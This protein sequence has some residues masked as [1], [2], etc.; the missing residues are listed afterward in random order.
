MSLSRPFI[1]RPVATSLL[2]IALVLIGIVAVRYLPVSS[3]PNVD[4]PTIQVHTSYP[5]ASPDVM[6]T[7]VT[8]PL[9]VQLGE[10]P[11]LQQMTSYSSDG[12]S[13]ITLQF[14]LSMSLDV[15]EQDVQQAIN[16]ANSYLPSGLPA[17]PTYA[18]VN[19]ADQPILTL[20]VTSKSM[21]LT[22]LQDYANNRLGTKISEVPGVGLVTTAGGNVPAVRVEADP[23]RLAA[24]NLN[25]DDLRTLLANV[26]ISQPKGNFDGPELDYT[27]NDNDQISDPND[28]LATIIAYQNGSPVYLHDVAR[29]TTAAQDVAQGATYN[30][31]PA[32]LLNVQRQPGANVIAT[33]DQIM[34]RLP[35]LESTLPAGVNVTAVSN[36]TGVIRA[37]VRDAAIELVMAVGLVVAV[38]FVFLRNVP[39]TIIPSISVP[40]S[41]IGTLAAMYELH[42]SIDNLSLMALIIATGFVVD[43]SIVM[44]ENVVRYLEEGESPL[45]AALKGAGQIGFTILSLTVSLIA[46]LIP[47]LFMGGVIGRLFSEFAVTLA[48]TVVLSAV[49]S[50]TVVPMLCARI[51]RA[52]AERQ[53]TRFERI[54]EGVFDKTL[55]AYERGLRWVLDHQRLT[56]AVGGGTVVLTVA[57]YIVIA[58][59]LFPIQDVGVIQ[60]ISV[61]DN[62]VSYKAMVERQSALADA[63]LRDRDVTSLTSYVGIDGTN[64]TLN[65]ARFLINLKPVDERSDSAEAIARRLQQEVANV[66]GIKLYLQPEQDLTLDTTVSPNQ[67][68]LAVRGPNQAALAKYV[69]ELV[70]RMKR[71]RSIADVTSDLGN[72]GLG[73]D[74][75]VNRQLAARYG[76]TPA[77]IDNALYNALGQR[78]V[79]TIFQQSDQHRVILVAKPETLPDV[80]SLGSLYLPTQTGTSGQVP[81]NGIATIKVVKSPLAISHLAQFPAVTVSFNLADGASLS[82]AAKQIEAAQKAVGLPSSITATF[83]GAAQAFEDSLSSEVYLIVAAIVAVYIVLGVL[84][85]SF[86]HPVTILS[87][88]PS[89]GVGALLALMIAGRDLDIIGIIGIVLLIGIVKKNAIMIVDFALEAEREHGKPPHEAI[90]EASLLRFRPILMTTMAAMLGA[91]PMLIGNGTGSELR[92]PLG[93]AIIGGLTVSQV[94]TVFTTPVIYLFF[95]RLARR[96]GRGP[97]AAAGGERSS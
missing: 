96:F 27:I 8:A 81:L 69:P 16:A 67:Y 65:H 44:I 59:G 54:S 68:R 87:T 34:K 1:L 63:I 72:D 9:E 22:Q 97:S 40:V 71:I 56:L 66:P 11:G 83:Q 30:R 17:P 79:S 36:S 53:P 57:L 45:Q 90:F 33:V 42:Y 23:H 77:T 82:T 2:M 85:E 73:I 29:V 3:L 61:A 38:I 20:A 52:Q 95:D 26:N 62:S 75:E 70:Q 78:I 39:A 55:A 32:I 5:G 80:Q 51:L 41:L 7:T 19:P 28:Y 12:S 31:T 10:I 6:A 25:L 15:A 88:L 13:I 92:R 49:V 74:V 21:S 76:I 18:K 50:L 4:Y 93:L 24:Y 60:G 89:A 37:S 94:L 14:D 47:L 84:Y 91:L 64:V 46:V 86:V 35:A 48:V 58:K 43:D